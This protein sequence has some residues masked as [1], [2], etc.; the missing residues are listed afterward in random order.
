MGDTRETAA[1]A[2][3]EKMG[4]RYESAAWDDA[5]AFRIGEPSTKGEF[6]QTI[7]IPAPDAPLHEELAFV[8]RLAE[9]LGIKQPSLAWDEQGKA[10]VSFTDDAYGIDRDLVTAAMLAAIQAKEAGR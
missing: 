1:R 8:G 9:A 10:I 6:H 2:L 3:A 4:W 5:I 7:Y